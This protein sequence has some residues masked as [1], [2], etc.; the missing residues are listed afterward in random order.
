LTIAGH[1]RTALPALLPE[2]TDFV[3]GE[4][5]GEAAGQFYEGQT[6]VNAP[7]SFT[8]GGARYSIM[9]TVWVAGIDEPS[10]TTLCSEAGADCRQFGEK[11]GGPLVAKTDDLG[12]QNI[13]TVYHFR[14]TGTLVSIAAYNYDVAGQATPVYLPTIPVT[15]DQLTALATDPDLAL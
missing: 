4:F 11:D 10:P 9:V 2:A 5:G 13:T 12:D 3:F 8:I 6:S 1:L 15:D 7:V 14:R